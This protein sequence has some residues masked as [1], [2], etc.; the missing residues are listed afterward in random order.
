MS[1]KVQVIAAFEAQRIQIYVS[2]SSS[3]LRR[4]S[5]HSRINQSFLTC[6][7]LSL[8]ITQSLLLLAQVLPGSGVEVVAAA[9]GFADV[10]DAGE[11]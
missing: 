5:R 10:A 2:I 6:T 9:A 1:S 8:Q 3:A 11:A 4:T 7:L